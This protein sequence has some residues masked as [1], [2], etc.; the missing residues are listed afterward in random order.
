MKFKATQ[1]LIVLALC[2]TFSC[3]AEETNAPATNNLA[4]D[5]DTNAPANKPIDLQSLKKGQPPV[6]PS[7]ARPVKATNAPAVTQ[8]AAPPKQLGIVI[9]GAILIDVQGQPA[10]IFPE[11]YAFDLTNH[12]YKGHY[13]VINKVALPEP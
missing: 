4:E 9:Y 12:V 13:Q 6:P 10:W 2:A 1:L 8:P 5:P 11:R 3:R 7:S